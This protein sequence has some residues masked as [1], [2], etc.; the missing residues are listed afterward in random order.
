MSSVNLIA[1]REILLKLRSKAFRI[2]TAALLVVVALGTVLP[3]LLLSGSS[4]PRRLGVVGGDAAPVAELA[5][6]LGTA[7]VDDGAGI[8]IVPLPDESAARSAVTEGEVDAALVGADRLLADGEPGQLVGLLETAR[9]RLRLTAALAQAGVAPEEVEGLLGPDP[10]T[11]DQVGEAGELEFGPEIGIGFLAVGLLYG[12][13]IYYGQLVA[14]GVVQEK[15]SRVVEI[16]V[17]SVEPVRLLAGKLLGLGLVGFGQIMALVLVASLGL[18]VGGLVE[19]TG[20]A[21]TTLLLVGA[22]YVLGF[23]LYAALFAL[24]GALVSRVEDLQSAAAPVI[25]LL[26]GS[27]LAVQFTLP[28][29]TSLAARIT[30]LVPFSAPLAQPLQ[31]VAGVGGWT[32]S[33][34]AIVLTL[35]TIAVLLPVAARVYRGGLLVTRGRIGLRDAFRSA[36]AVER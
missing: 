25:V 12:L 33:L 11:V 21:V 26:V 7:S 22:W 10:L 29:P 2:V 1:R 19:A 13:L 30:A 3:G 32:S 14:Q 23:A 18:V 24:A 16:L 31:I 4:E 27:L 20:A 34:L 15:Q 5:R 36:A 35:A 17:S 9:T 8:D 28:N 6:S